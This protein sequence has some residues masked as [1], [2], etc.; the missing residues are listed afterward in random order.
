[1]HFVG[2]FLSSLLKM[3]GPKNKIVVILLAFFFAIWL[4]YLLMLFNKKRGWLV[5]GEPLK[6]KHLSINTTNTAVLTVCT[7]VMTGNCYTNQNF[8]VVFVVCLF[9][10]L[11]FEGGRCYK[12]HYF[13][14]SIRCTMHLLLFCTMTNKC[15]IISQIIALLHI[16]TLWCN[17]LGAFNQY[18]AKL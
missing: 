5:I 2:L 14:I 16:S 8:V 10:C 12:I 17:P 6:L 4:K 9:V 15:T 13:V 18:L 11:I 7:Y 3:H 1:M